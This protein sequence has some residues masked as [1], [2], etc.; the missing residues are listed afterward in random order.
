MAVTQDLAEFVKEALTRGM[1]RT[2][3][4][5]VLTKAGWHPNQVKDALRAYAEID[6]PLP[7]P[8]PRPYV[9]AREAFSYLALFA[10]LYVCAYSL[11]ALVFDSIDWWL[12]E[13]GG[14]RKPE[15][16]AESMRW[17]IA[18]LVVVIPVFVFASSR[19]ASATRRDPTARLSPV[20]RQLTYAT[21]FVASAVI[22]GD[23]ASLVYH[24]LGGDLTVRF[25]LKVLTVGII[26]GA[27]FTYCLR[28]IRGEE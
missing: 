3:I 28:G 21:M 7:V 17:A 23:L 20:R 5:D 9:S 11:G 27:G 10:S 15:M 24:L 18:W 6:A 8:R 1:S 26:A 14:R 19:V 12:P 25:V 13:P 22:I 16:V 2:D 4:A